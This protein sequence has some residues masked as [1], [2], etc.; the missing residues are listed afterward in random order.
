MDTTGELYLRAMTFVI[1]TSVSATPSLAY[2]NAYNTLMS[3]VFYTV[4]QSIRETLLQSSGHGGVQCFIIT[5]TEIYQL[6][7]MNSL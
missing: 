4:I 7:T 2:A 5:D 6:F 1:S 3:N